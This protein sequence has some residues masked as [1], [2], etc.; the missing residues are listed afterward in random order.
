MICH[1]AQ[2][3]QCFGVARAYFQRVLITFLGL[4]EPARSHLGVSELDPAIDGRRL[5]GGV[6]G[7]VLH[8]GQRVV[9]FERQDTQVVAG[10][11]Q[12]EIQLQGLLV[13]ALRLVQVSRPVV[14]QAEVIPCLR[15]FRQQPRRIR[16]VL[17]GRFVAVLLDQTFAFQQRARPG[18]S[19]S[20]QKRCAHRNRPCQSKNRPPISNDQ[21]AASWYHSRSTVSRNAQSY[22]RNFSG[23][24]MPM[25]FAAYCAAA[26]VER[27]TPATAAP[28]QPRVVVV[29]DLQ[30]TYAFK[31]DP[32]IVSNMVAK[33]TVQVTGKSNLAAA[34]QS[35][36][37]TQDVIGLKVYSS[38]GANSGTR[39]AVA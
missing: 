19:A 36:A 27:I 13:C 11:R 3:V 16:Q 29:R 30:A 8:R 20:A 33:A 35:L 5:K 18:C 37:T 26:S 4:V 14:G 17:D 32:Q 34:W 22:L 23:F 15:A 38:P 21:H 39:P 28:S 2:P 25:A 6:A 7:E 24:L 12:I 9:L 1:V 31:A 10:R